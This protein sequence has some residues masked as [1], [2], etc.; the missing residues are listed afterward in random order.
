MR[1]HDVDGS[2][3]GDVV[4]AVV[5]TLLD[6]H[7]MKYIYVYCMYVFLSKYIW[8]AIYKLFEKF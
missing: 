1:I 3:D 4:G 5:L 2:G 6:C 7:Y 8:P